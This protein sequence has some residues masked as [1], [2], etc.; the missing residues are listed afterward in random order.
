MSWGGRKKKHQTPAVECFRIIM[1]VMPVRPQSEELEA[2][3]CLPGMHKK[4]RRLWGE[5]IAAFQYL[6][7][8]YK[9]EGEQ[10]WIVI[11]QEGIV[12]NW[13]WEVQ[14]RYQ[15]EVSYTEGGDTLEPVAQG[16]CGCSI[17]GFIQS[18][19]GCDSGQPGLVVGDPEH[20]RGV[21]T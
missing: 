16:G 18:Q 14:L 13:D 11:G 8:A 6:K 7:G 10:E 19:A 2:K 9:Q 17:P 20:S 21:E 3:G 12:L 15:E 1:S 5:L 4:K